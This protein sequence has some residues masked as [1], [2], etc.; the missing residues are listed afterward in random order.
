MNQLTTISALLLAG[1]ASVSGAASAATTTTTINFDGLNQAAYGGH[2]NTSA[3]GVCADCYAE[4][5]FV[6]GVVS[7]ANPTNHLH[8]ELNDIAPDGVTPLYEVAYHNDSSGIYMRAVDGSSFSLTQMDFSAPFGIAAGNARSGTWEILGFSQA[9]N[10]GL[11]SGNGTDYATRVAYQTVSNT[12]ANNFS[13]TLTLNSGFQNI[14]A[15]WIHFLGEPDSFVTA[16]LPYKMHLDNVVIQQTS[17]VPVPA[18]VWMFGSGLL[19]LLSFG[20]K[21]NIALAA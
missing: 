15:F 13:G 8:Q 1:M 12:A 20:R 10:A 21:K 19:G 5:G 9:N 14:S 18:A 2:A 6:L 11:S 7:D 16:G 17:A 4:S 3:T